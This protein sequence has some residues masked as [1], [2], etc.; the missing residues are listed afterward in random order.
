MATMPLDA[1][2]ALAMTQ[3]GLSFL[4]T[5]KADQ[6][7]AVTQAEVLTGLEGAEARLTAARSADAVRVL[8]RARL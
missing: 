7:P 5:C 6:L 2:D 8:R 4:A 3:A 1:A